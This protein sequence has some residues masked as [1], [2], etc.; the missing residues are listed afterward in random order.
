VLGGVL[1]HSNSLAQ[2]DG[3]YLYADV[4]VGDVR[5]FA[6]SKP[7]STDRSTGM[8]VKLPT[9]ITQPADGHVYIT[10]LAGA[11]YRVKERRCDRDPWRHFSRP[12]CLE[13][14]SRL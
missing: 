9:S 4:C 8:Q 1:V 6:P 3:R 11:V 12:K 13:L 5:S 14:W 7:D 10:S 2:V